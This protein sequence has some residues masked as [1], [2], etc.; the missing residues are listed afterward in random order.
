MNIYDINTCLSSLSH[1]RPFFVSEADFQHCFALELRKRNF[2]VFLEFPISLTGTKRTVYLDLLVLD[3]KNN[4]L[5]PIELKFKTKRDYCHGLAI[6]PQFQ[7]KT[8]SAA[9]INRY[10]VWK[11]VNR[12]EL[13]KKQYNYGQGFVIMLTNDEQYW[14]PASGPG[15][16]DASFRLH[17][18]QHVQSILWQNNSSPNIYK[19]GTATYPGFTLM[20]SY[21]VPQWIFYSTGYSL[22]NPS[23]NFR[24]LVIP[25]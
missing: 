14:T 13:I 1:Y 11:D 7:L 24:V 20:N 5:H 19:C 8:H 15:V 12:I 6:Q 2:D 22:I 16:I 17:P 21:I 25:V 23:N 18:K 9:D 4:T 3:H 10:L